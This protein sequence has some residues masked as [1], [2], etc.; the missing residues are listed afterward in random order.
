MC[1]VTELPRTTT[2]QGLP[3]ISK[4]LPIKRKFLLL[5]IGSTS[6]CLKFFVIQKYE[7]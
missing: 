4:T 2:F 7:G 6:K 5:Q 3:I 1:L